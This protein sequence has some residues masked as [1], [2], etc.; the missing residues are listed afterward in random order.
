SGS[1]RILHN[2]NKKATREDNTR[3]MEIARRHD[4][5]VKALMSI[6]HPGESSETVRDTRDW[7]MEVKP[8]DFDVTII[9]TYPGCEYYD[10]A[11]PVDGRPGEWV[12]AVNGDRLY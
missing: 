6:G 7:L 11:V 9:T 3:C 10:S 2:I 12:Y 5:K 8:D 1:P 4:L